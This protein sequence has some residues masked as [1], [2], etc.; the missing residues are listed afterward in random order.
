MI[1]RR[2]AE[3]LGIVLPAEGISFAAR[4]CGGSPR[5]LGHILNTIAVTTTGWR[6]EQDYLGNDPTILLE[7]VEEVAAL[8]GIDGLGLDATGRALLAALGR[9]PSFSSSAEA[10]SIATGLDLPYVRERL[11]DLRHWG[12]VTAAPGRGWRLTVNPNHA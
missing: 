4:A 9:Q 1:A 2:Q 3:A 6:Y 10:L 8:M 12:L 5:T 7:T 11:A